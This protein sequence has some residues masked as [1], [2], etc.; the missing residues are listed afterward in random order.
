MKLLGT[1]KAKRK[2][3]NNKTLEVKI[4]DALGK[5]HINIVPKIDIKRGDKVLCYLYKNL[6][7]IQIEK[8]KKIK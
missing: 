3:Y 2:G 6:Y 7:S 4:I 1:I 8:I 5:I